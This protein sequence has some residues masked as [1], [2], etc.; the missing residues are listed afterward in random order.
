MFRDYVALLPRYRGVPDLRGVALQRAFYGFVPNW[1]D[2]RAA[3]A[4]LGPAALA[5]HPVQVFW[6]AACLA[7]PSGGPLRCPTCAVAYWHLPPAVSP[8]HRGEE[9]ARAGTTLRCSRSPRA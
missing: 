2:P 9:R 8:R 3:A 5:H 4:A 6:A 1:C 7:L